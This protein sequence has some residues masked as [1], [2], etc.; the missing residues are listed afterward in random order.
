[1]VGWVVFVVE[2]NEFVFYIDIVCFGLNFENVKI[3][4]EK[5]IEWMVGVW[6]WF[7]ELLKVLFVVLE[8][9]FVFGIYGL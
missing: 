8:V 3:F 1:M 2:F 5:V 4:S 6:E 9:Y 7:F